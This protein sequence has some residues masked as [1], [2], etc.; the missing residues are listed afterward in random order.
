MNVVISNAAAIAGKFVVIL[1]HIFVSVISAEPPVTTEQ[2][3]G[4]TIEIVWT[5][6][7]TGF[8]KYNIPTLSLMDEISIERIVEDK[9]AACEAAQA[10]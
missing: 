7:K 3:E 4:A 2:L 10:Q 9:V 1:L 5:D 8:V 6:C